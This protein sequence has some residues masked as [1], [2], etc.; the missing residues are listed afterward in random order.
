MNNVSQFPRP[1]QR[2]FEG[3]A[4]LGELPSP[5]PLPEG[6]TY[7]CFGG[8]W[9]TQFT[10]PTLEESGRKQLFDANVPATESLRMLNARLLKVYEEV[11]QNI[12][13]EA[14]HDAVKPHVDELELVIVNM[15]F[16]INSLRVPQARLQLAKLITEQAQELDAHADLLRLR[17]QQGRE[18]LRN[19]HIEIETMRKLRERGEMDQILTAAESL[20]ASQ[21]LPPEDVSANQQATTRAA[22]YARAAEIAAAAIRH[23]RH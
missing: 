14:E 18:C 19:V 13:Q 23:E 4:S 16:L 21:T 10:M 12:A 6:T 1:P 9:S 5:P 20:A 17:M 7:S 15:H 2:L 11:V 22:L 8:T 3:F